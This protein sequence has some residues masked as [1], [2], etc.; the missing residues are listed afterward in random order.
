M[1]IKCK[2]NSSWPIFILEREIRVRVWY[3]ELT[4]QK[5]SWRGPRGEHIT[6]N[7]VGG[8]PAAAGAGAQ[9]GRVEA[10]LT[11]GRLR[12]RASVTTPYPSIRNPPDGIDLAPLPLHLSLSRKGAIYIYRLVTRLAAYICASLPFF[13]CLSLFPNLL[14]SP[15]TR[16]SGNTMQSTHACALRN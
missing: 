15:I 12:C 5:S 1:S 13:A 6:E 2:K 11:A 4:D 7:N 8:C 9:S 10:R 16:I 3:C 14:F